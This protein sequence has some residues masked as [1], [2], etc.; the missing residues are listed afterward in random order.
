MP[1]QKVRTRFREPLAAGTSSR[2]LVFS[3]YHKTVP[4][5]STDRRGR[6]ECQKFSIGAL[7][8]ERQDRNLGPTKFGSEAASADVLMMEGKL[9]LFQN[10]TL[11]HSFVTTL[12]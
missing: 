5:G 8:A 10:F 7:M 3:F 11:I 6:E 12:S 4:C 9:D 2:N 1:S